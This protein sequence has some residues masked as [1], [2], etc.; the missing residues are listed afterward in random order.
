MTREFGII[1]SIADNVIIASGLEFAF[2][3]EVVSFETSAYLNSTSKTLDS[4]E[5]PKALVMNLEEKIVRLAL[6]QGPI[7]SV[8]VGQK[9]YRT[10]KGVKTVAG[11]CLLGSIVNPLGELID[12]DKSVSEFAKSKLLSFSY[13]TLFKKPADIISRDTVAIPFLTGI[14]AIDCFLPIGYGQRQLIIGDLNSGKTSLAI[15]MILNQRFIINNVD[16]V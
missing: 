16:R 5:L 12:T 10:Y 3:G 13:T 1:M 7:A 11:L 14:I 15:T 4:I 6:F 2:V 8:Y 9:M